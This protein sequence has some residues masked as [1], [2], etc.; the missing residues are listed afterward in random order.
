MAGLMALQRKETTLAPI[1]LLDEQSGNYNIDY[2]TAMFEKNS[3]ALIKGVGRIQGIMVKKGNPLNVLGIKDL[4]RIRYVNRQRGAG[5]RL[6]LDHLLKSQNISAAHVN[7]YAR[8]AA[9]HMAV[10]AAVL[11]DSA[12]A[13][14]VYFLRPRPWGWILFRSEMRIMILPFIAVIWTSCTSRPFLRF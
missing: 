7:G 2:L 4:T 9:T 11:S 6:L 8:E 1:H 14:W 5:T 3:V 10:A 13:V 12:D